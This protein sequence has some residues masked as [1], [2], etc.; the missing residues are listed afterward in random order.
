M[1]FKQ[2]K[3]EESENTEDE[4]SEKVGGKINRLSQWSKTISISNDI[5][6]LYLNKSLKF[7]MFTFL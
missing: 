3:K 1:E 7:L 4:G 6:G 2:D 5:P